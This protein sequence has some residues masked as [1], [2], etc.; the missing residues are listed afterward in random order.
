MSKLSR[1]FAITRIF[2]TILA[3]SFSLWSVVAPAADEVVEPGDASSAQQTDAASPVSPPWPVQVTDNGRTFLIYQPQVDKWENNRL[4]GRSAVSVRNDAS[5]QQNFGVVYF[6]ARTELDQGSRTVTV[7]DAVVSKA[8][9]PAVT[10]GVDDYLSVLR[11]QFAA[12]SWQVAQDRLQS[13]MEIDRLAQQSSMQPL[14]NDPPRMLYSERPA[15][16]VPIDGNPALRPVADTGL[17]RVANTR[18]LILQDK[19]TSRYY[20]FVA[21][22]WM[23]SRGLEGPWS[24]AANPS[25]QLEQARQLATQQD[26]VDLLQ[27]DAGDGAVTPASVVVFVST[28]PTELLQT[29]GP[30]QYSPIERTQLLYVTNSPNKLFLDLRT[31][32]HY[33]LISGRWY[34]A[35]TLAQGPWSYVPVASLPTDFA[36]IPA[37]H[38]T[39]SVR[40]A[41]PGTPQAREAVIANTVPQVATVARS[42][43][44]LEI[45]YDGN[46]VFQPIEGTALQNAANSPVPVIRVSEASFYA[47][48]NGVWFV[49][50]SPFGPWTVTSYVPSVIY[51]IPRS[52]PL[53]NV[54]YVR[55]YDATPEV[56]YVGYTPGYVG[57]YVSSDDVV[58]YG[59]GWPYR[60]WIG[61][62]W[63]GAPVT[64]G[65]GFS[66][67]YSWWDP[68][69]W[70]SWHR[71]AWASPRPYYH[72]WWG[73]WHAPLYGRSGYVAGGVNAIG[74]SGPGFH[75]VGRIYDRWDSRS[76]VWNGSRAIANQQR[77]AAPAV[78]RPAPRNGF[79]SRPDGRWQRLGDDGNRARGRRDAQVRGNV[80]NSPAAQMPRAVQALPAVQ[81]PW[82][83][84]SIAN[85]EDRARMQSAQPR[86]QPPSFAGNERRPADNRQLPPRER[87]WDQRQ[88]NEVLPR[89]R[90][91]GRPI[92][93]RPR[94]NV[95]QNRP[96]PQGQ[97]PQR[98]PPVAGVPIERVPSQFQR[99]LPPSRDFSPPPGRIER[100]AIT[101]PGRIERPALANP[102]RIERSVV[103]NP[104]RGMERPSVNSGRSV[105]RSADRPQSRSNEGRGQSNSGGGRGEYRGGERNR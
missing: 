101:N 20:L 79:V 8:D 50:S 39:E 93:D 38:P 29:D 90:V 74:R 47:L 87:V 95:Q 21:D 17:L 81:T 59:T 36:M 99:A 78:S 49:A 92:I 35:T 52:S 76:V 25:A 85:Q 104:G 105:E 28:T 46:P 13:D 14:K 1:V 80:A 23:E 54:T 34:R 83:R 98:I 18:A 44:H 48:D 2:V 24:V 16:L 97:S 31:Q 7:R 41:V 72:P 75:N 58:V 69:P 22:H 102:G 32:N 82:R 64:W 61:S 43:A 96:A 42:T 53:Y 27:A 65:F 10:T 30:A 51:S 9:F 3:A 37:E 86:V 60:P 94:A 70:H 45:T 88:A 26:Q 73:P 77:L 103:A 57:S 33:A 63:Y 84:P 68:Y 71:V 5:G 62:V 15:V 89:A 12:H 56:V 19:A 6:S 100:P 67:F 40:A 91:D 66:F 4:E 11:P 55:V